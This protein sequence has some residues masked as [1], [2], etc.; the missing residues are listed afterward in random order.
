[1]VCGLLV[2]GGFGGVP[3]MVRVSNIDCMSVRSTLCGW[4]SG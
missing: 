4:N 1:M 3:M 2:R